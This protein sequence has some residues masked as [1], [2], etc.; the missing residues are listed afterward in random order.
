MNDPDPSTK[1]G[2]TS[3]LVLLLLGLLMVLAGMIWR[4]SSAIEIAQ[5]SSEPATQ[6]ASG[7][8]KAG[9]D[10]VIATSDVEAGPQ[11]RGNVEEVAAALN[12]AIAEK[13]AATQADAGVGLGVE[14][15][16][17][18][19]QD[20]QSAD[21]TEADVA[22]PDATAAGIETD[23]ANTDIAEIETAETPDSLEAIVPEAK[24]EDY[25]T[26][27]AVLGDALYFDLDDEDVPIGLDLV[28]VERDGAA[29]VAGFGP[30]GDEL[31]LLM[32]GREISRPVADDT[33]RF[34]SLFDIPASDA[35]RSLSVGLI[36][37]DGNPRLSHTQVLIAP[38]RI[39]GTA[40]LIEDV[41]TQPVKAEP[42]VVAVQDD[43]VAVLQ[44][45]ERPAIPGT[46]TARNIVID[47]IAYDGAGEVELQGRGNGDSFVRVYID[48]LAVQTVEADE[49]GIWSVPLP[50]IDEGVYRLRVDELDDDGNVVSRVE[51]PFQRE[52]LSIA[53][54][55][56]G[57]ITV[58]PGFTLW[59]IARETLGDGVKYVQVYEANRDLIRDP[60]L[61]YP[62]QV[63]ALP[64]G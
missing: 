34:V 27:S 7:E 31:V 23:D 4:Q 64:E 8:V 14:A 54:D 16:T 60:N 3:T 52:K 50:N 45:A 35:P 20:P 12:A 38:V 10:A 21:K 5:G 15:T 22:G 40:P 56:S 25:Q 28:R 63:F 37:A 49:D 9:E 24:D 32:G 26:A 46:G 48:D 2:V 30:A 36:G 33:G 41:D 51:T 44:P 17:A 42:T 19:G 29:L 13:T 6:T 59:A 18:S 61:I 47:T 58:Q 43:E 55:A 62:G 53:A 11:Q 39:A 57:S 1:R